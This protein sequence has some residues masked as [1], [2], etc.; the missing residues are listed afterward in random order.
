MEEDTGK[1]DFKTIKKMADF[2]YMKNVP[3]R[4]KHFG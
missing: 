1:S 3:H 2:S 4:T